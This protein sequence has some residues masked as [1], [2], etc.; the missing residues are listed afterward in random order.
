MS[1]REH[2]DAFVVYDRRLEKAASNLGL[3]VV[4]PG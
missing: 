3:N 2:L 4:S 1:V